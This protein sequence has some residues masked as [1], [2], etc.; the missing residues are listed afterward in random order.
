M[1]VLVVLVLAVFTGCNAN[2]LYADD[3]KSQ[4][5]V[6]TDAISD[7]ID[8]VVQKATD[9]IEQFKKTELGQDLSTRVKDGSE[10]VSMYA[11]IAWEQVPDGIKNAAEGAGMMVYGISMRVEQGI[12]VLEKKLEPLVDRVSPVAEKVAEKV[13]G[14]VNYRAQQVSEAASPYV[15]KIQEKLTPLAQ[16]IQARLDSLYQSVVKAN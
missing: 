8:V 4:L 15:A 11:G 14:E 7:N 16:G 2:F 5:D 13:A 9:T 3:P 1:K 6:L 12:D 10:L